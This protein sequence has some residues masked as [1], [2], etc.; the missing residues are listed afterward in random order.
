MTGRDVAV[1]V[2]LVMCFFAFAALSIVLLQVLSALRELRSDLD[3]FESRVLPLMADLRDAT[4]ETREVV[5]EA[6]EDLERFDRVLGSAE[7]VSSALADT[8]RV[9]RT[10]IT[11][12]L[13]KTVA[14]ARG[15]SRG[16]RKFSTSAPTQASRRKTRQRRKSGR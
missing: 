4:D 12:P 15:V 3:L 14:V 1:I 7:M 5:D 2:G 13:I 6:R 16:L 9:A 8:S 11:S 10:V